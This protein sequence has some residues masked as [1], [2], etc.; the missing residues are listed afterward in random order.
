MSRSSPFR[1]RA[2]EA[3]ADDRLRTAVMSATTDRDARRKAEWATLT[4]VDGL[5][6][7]GRQIKA[8]TLDNLDEYL[9]QLIAS[10]ERAGVSVHFASDAEDANRRIIEIAR[11]HRCRRLVKGKSMLSEELHLNAALERAGLEVVET[12]LGEYLLQLDGQLP[13]HITCPAVHKDV[14]SCATTL[15]QHL[16]VD[17]T[18]DPEALVKIARHRMRDIFRSADMAVTGVNF[19]VAESGT[20]VLVMNE[21]NGRFCVLN[22]RVHVAVM[23]IE[24]VVPTLQDLSVMLKLL[25]RSATSQKLSVDTHLITGPKRFDDADG[26]EH[27]HVVIVDAGRTGMLAGPYREALSCIRCGACLNTCPVYRSIGG[28]AY[29]GVYPGPIGKLVTALL[30]QHADGAELPQASTLCG[31]CADACPV[32]I[33]IPALLLRMRADAIGKRWENRRKSRLLR[34]AMWAM[35]LRIGYV[36]TQRILRMLMRLRGKQ[37]QWLSDGPGPIRHWTAAGRDMKVPP[38]R[39]FRDLWRKGEIS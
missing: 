38:R 9:K 30:R 35:R 34:P 36:I 22:S 14:A 16:N 23:G 32:K 26:P 21:G 18:E 17:Y 4:D 10:F 24:K 1:L 12:D 31:A 19:A 15:T 11:R 13:S 3:V 37:S 20:V 7:L 28:H 29:G 39:S 6:E 2:A 5:R 33:N 27:M 25:A 8:H